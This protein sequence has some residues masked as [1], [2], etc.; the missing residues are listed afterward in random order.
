MYTIK[1][2]NKCQIYALMTP[3]HVAIHLLPKL[4]TELRT[5]NVTAVSYCK[6]EPAN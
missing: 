4:E 1:V 6:G 3:M 2:L 5:R